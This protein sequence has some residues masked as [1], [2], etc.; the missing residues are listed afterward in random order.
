MW[1]TSID[2]ILKNIHNIYDL[3]LKLGIKKHYLYNKYMPTEN[4]LPENNNDTLKEK[5]TRIKTNKIETS[6]VLQGTITNKK[7]NLSKQAENVTQERRDE[8]TK[9]IKK[10]VELTKEDEKTFKISKKEGLAKIHN[11]KYFKNKKRKELIDFDPDKGVFSFQTK[12]DGEIKEF[13]KGDKFYILDNKFKTKTEYEV[14]GTRLEDKIKLLR[15]KRVNKSGKEEIAEFD[16]K[17]LQELLKGTDGLKLKFDNDQTDAPNKISEDTKF[18]KP[19]KI[20]PIDTKIKKEEI[21]TEETKQIEELKKT[22]ETCQ[23]KL[24]R[25]DEIKKRIAFLKEQIAKQ[26]NNTDQNNTGGKI[27]P[28]NI[29]KTEAPK[30][31]ETSGTKENETN[32][33]EIKNDTIEDE[34]IKIIDRPLSTEEIKQNIE[35]ID[36]SIQK[37][38]KEIL[39]KEAEEKVYGEKAREL[40]LESTKREEY[41]EKIKDNLKTLFWL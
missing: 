3:T 11:E 20:T 28:E 12:E 17:R 25:I 10:R 33:I 21:I 1:I 26:E 41:G 39:A 23:K 36:N 2:K 27:D 8:K 15:T 22:I 18:E 30:K 4:N 37:K 14:T 6:L 16:T 24:D 5:R 38:E 29:L 34:T 40:L 13:K 7:N 35:T 19:K 31:N 32:I 9:E